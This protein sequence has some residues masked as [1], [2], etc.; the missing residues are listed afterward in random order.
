MTDT[1]KPTRRDILMSSLLLPLTAGA[2]ASA[3]EAEAAPLAGKSLVAFFTRSGNTS[4]IAGQ[5][6]RVLP[7]ELFEIA[8]ATPY[9]ADY[10]QTV[11]QARRERDRGYRP[12]L[13]SQLASTAA[14]AT[15]FLGFPIWGET[16]P[17]VIRSF[18]AF[19]DLAGKTIVP[20]ITHGGFGPGDSLDVVASHA[21]QSRLIKGLTM[22]RP[23]ERQTIELVT[24][25]LKTLDVD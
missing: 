6:S 20:F 21:P 12:P 11:D 2:A 23:Q 17:P 19:H 15:V 16:A 25:W 18:L 8:P 7:A 5:L 22:Q 3:A 14:Y 13:R 1:D 10:F 24:Q 4:V 9:P